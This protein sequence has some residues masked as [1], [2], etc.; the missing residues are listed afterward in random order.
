MTV[1][2]FIAF[3]QGNKIGLLQFKG[4]VYMEGNDMVGFEF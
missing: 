4:L 1:Y 2:V 3:T